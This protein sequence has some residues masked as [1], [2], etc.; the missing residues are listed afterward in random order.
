MI[1]K[2]QGLGIGA[3]QGQVATGG[4]GGGQVKPHDALPHGPAEGYVGAVST[5]DV[6]DRFPAEIQNL[7]HLVR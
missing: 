1:G 5:A 7:L 6:Q 2:G 4:R 3:H